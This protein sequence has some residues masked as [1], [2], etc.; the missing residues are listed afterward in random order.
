MSTRLDRLLALER[1]IRSGG[2]PS[3]EVLCEL[4]E[5]QPRT[6]YQDLKELR[7]KFGL[8]IRFDRDKNG[9]FNAD[10][11]KSLPMATITREEMMLVIIAQEML[12]EYGGPSFRGLLSNALDK[13]KGGQKTGDTPEQLRAVIRFHVDELSQVSRRLFVDLLL[14]CLEQRVINL[15]HQENEQSAPEGRAF[16]GYFIT[17]TEKGWHLMGYCRTSDRA[18]AIP[19]NSIVSYTVSSEHFV[20]RNGNYFGK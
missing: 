3:I 9:Y 18:F 16:E 6:I 7:E 20:E 8:D 1:Q 4:F 17:R 14:A 12:C 11:D 2:Y 19:L 15:S 10:P 5:V 13:I